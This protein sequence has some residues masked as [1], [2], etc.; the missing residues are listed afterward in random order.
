MWNKIICCHYHCMNFMFSSEFHGIPPCMHSHPL[1]KES[2]TS[3]NRWLA[4]SLFSKSASFYGRSWRWCHSSIS[5]WIRYGARMG[6]P[7]YYAVNLILRLFVPFF[8][9][10]ELR[11]HPK[12][13]KHTTNITT[14][15]VEPLAPPAMWIWWFHATRGAGGLAHI[16]SKAAIEGFK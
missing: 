4:L 12:Q 7:K 6:G 9:Y 11:V 2:Q 3:Q 1:V 8:A 15:V 16:L 14:M 13:H 5:W 10:V